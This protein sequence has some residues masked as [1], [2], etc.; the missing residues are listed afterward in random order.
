MPSAKKKSLLIVCVALVL[1]LMGAQKSYQLW[2]NL[3]PDLEELLPT[4]A[5][6]V[7]DLQEVGRR[8]ESM[9]SFVVL[10]FSK[11]INQ[12]KKFVD[13]LANKLTRL[14][15]SLLTRVDYKIDRELRFFKKR[16]LLYLEVEDLKK[17]RSYIQKRIS[18]EREL[19][20]PLLIFNHTELKEPKLDL[21]AIE[22]RYELATQDFEHFPGGYYATSDQT[23]RAVLVF[24]PGR[25]TDLN[26]LR[27]VH[28][29]IQSA[30]DSLQPK[31]FASDMEIH[32][33]GG[34]QNILE[35]QEALIEDVKWS[36]LIVTVLVTSVLVFY[37]RSILEIAAL[38]ISLFIGT[39]WTFGL[40]YLWI[41]SLNA[42]SAFLFSIIVG[43]GI[44]FGI[45]L[46]AR[47]QENR[48]LLQ[49][50]NGT[51]KPTLTA[52]L[53]A[54]FA[55][56]SLILTDF[57]GFSQF[58][59]IGLMGMILCWISAFTV[60][61][62]LLILFNPKN[63][64]PPTPTT[65][66][67]QNDGRL[68]PFG[69]AAVRAIAWLSL[70]GVA[71]SLALVT[72]FSKDWIEADLT[73]LRSK[74]SLTSGSAYY[75]QYQTEI[76]GR[77]LSPFAILTPSRKDAGKVA[78]ALKP[79]K[80]IASVQSIDSFLP[81]EQ[82]T[83]LRLLREIRAQLRPEILASLPPKEQT[84]AKSFFEPAIRRPVRLKDLPPLVKNSFREKNGDIG[85]IVLVEPPAGDQ[86]HQRDVLLNLVRELRMI[87]DSI[88]PGAPIA[89]SLAVSA[90]ILEAIDRSGP[91]AMAVAFSAV[92]GWVILLLRDP[93]TISWVL[94]SLFMGVLW[95]GALVAVLK[96]KINFLNFIAFPITFGIGVDYGVNIFQ[97]IYQ[98]KRLLSDEQK[99]LSALRSTGGAVILCSLTTIIGYCSLLLAQN[100][101][102]VSFGQIA[103]LGELACVS[104]AVIALPALLIAFRSRSSS[105]ATIY[106]PQAGWPK[107]DQDPT[108]TEDSHKDRG[109][110]RFG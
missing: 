63:P 70:L 104:A 94:G 42:N 85:K 103:V 37:F 83:K 44:N 77:Y 91:K 19:Y 40:T 15:K 110:S 64:K 107:S 54:G 81:K 14:P 30:I 66:P 92:V 5:R 39:F 80:F 87:T 88:V 10:I 95:L 89:G 55:Y 3:R 79:M 69:R 20:N 7:K 49:A 38:L 33:T 45:I 97:R 21:K 73:R 93:R 72:V 23:K 101:A 82:T 78:S 100:N 16:R 50:M 24:V 74:K 47:Y 11:N 71:V 34:P 2:K 61:P 68:S 17:I 76:F 36:S 51:L 53:G 26:R 27:A 105:D 29:A 52:A 90:D 18:Y 96:I 108:P 13:Q 62:A 41:G 75:S 1:A 109:E 60:L 46:L 102:F 12:S 99:L 8:L 48:N 35:E 56:G 6:S 98:E 32:F 59:M 84:Q 43:N 22:A 106:Y 9:D 25:L 65:N 28:D 67:N 4:D 58:G 57:R 31:K 86:T